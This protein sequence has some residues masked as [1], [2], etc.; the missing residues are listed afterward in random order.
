MRLPPASDRLLSRNR[1]EILAELLDARTSFV[2]E[3]LPE[4]GGPGRGLAEIAAGQFELLQRRLAQVP[5]HRLA[6]LLDMLGGS[7]LPAQGARTH[8][9]MIAPPGTR[10]SLVPRGA[11]IGAAV[12]GRDAPVVFETQDDVAISSAAIAE[13]HSVLPGSD[14]EQDHSADVLGHRAFAI[15]GDPR[16]V[17]REL[18]VGHDE[19]LAFDGRSVVE[20][21]FGISVPPPHPLPIEW[22]WWDG[23][24]WRPFARSVA[25]ADA[26]GDDDSV[27]GTAGLTRSGTVRLVAPVATAVPLEV[28]GHRTYWIRGRLTA[29][30]DLPDG[31]P[32]PTVSRLRLAVLNEHRRLRVFR[33]TSPGAPAT[34]TIAWAD[35]KDDPGLVLVQR[36]ESTG[37]D[38]LQLVPG[39]P[40]AADPVPSSLGPTHREGLAVGLAQ[41][42]DVRFGVDV[43]A[44]R[45][46]SDPRD[47]TTPRRV[48]LN[49]L[50][51]LTAP[52]RIDE[53][54]QLTLV[55]KRGLELD[56]G[57]ADRRAVDLT[58]TFAPLGPS[59]ERG[60]AFHFACA[61]ATARPGSRVTLVIERPSTASE[62]AD[63][64]A[65]LQ[66]DAAA[67]TIKER[68]E[69]VTL[70]STGVVAD[71]ELA[72]VHL[73]DA[74]AH[75]PDLLGPAIDAVGE[76]AT[77]WFAKLR[78]DL[79]VG[80]QAVRD[81]VDDIRDAAAVA[82]G[83]LATAN[84][85]VAAGALVSQGFDIDS[86]YTALNALTPLLP[87]F[88]VPND[89]LAQEP[90]VFLDQTRARLDV[91][92]A[93]IDRAKAK[94]ATA[95]DRL[96]RLSPTALAV[97]LAR[98]ETTK[99]TP[100]RVDWE[101]YDGTTWRALG[102]SGD[103]RVVSLMDSGALHFTVPD[104]ISD[105][106]LDGD[107]RRWLRARL[108]GGTFARM[109]LVSWV[110]PKNTT[111]FLS[112]VEP[113]PPVIDRIEVF[114]THRSESS[115]AAAVRVHDVHRWDDLTGAVA[116]P[117]TGSTPFVPM[118]ESAPCLYV[119]FD[120]ELP[121]G[122][123]GLWM[124]PATPSPWASPH[125]PVWE[126]WDG[127]GWVRLPVEDGTD[128]FRRPGVVRLLWP[129]TDAAAGVTVVG[130]LG[131]RITLA[132]RG[133][134]LRFAPGDRLL[135]TDAQ[136]QASV[137]VAEASGE[138]VVARTPVPRA[139][140]GARLVPAPPSRFGEP[141]T[142]VRA[143]FD[144][145]RPP[146]SLTLAS[147]APHA[148]EV[149]QSESIEG[150][151]LGSGDGTA[152][153]VMIAQRFPIAEDVLLEVR[154]LD[155]DRADLDREVLD[156]TLRREGIDPATVRPVIDS[157]TR[158]VTE[159]W[160]PWRRVDAL[161]GAAGSD[162]VFV[163]DSAQ[164]R[165]LFGDAVHGR[166]LPSGI[167]NVRLRRYSTTDGRSGNVPTGA[168]SQLLN[169]VPISE[170]VNPL[171]ATGGAEAEGLDAALRR[172][173]ALLRHRRLALT[174]SDVEA[175]ACEASPAVVRAR[176]V[177]ARDRWGR[178]RP[179]AVRVVI[180]PRDGSARPA[181]GAALRTVVHD[182]V[183]AASPA[184]V[185]S[186]VT[187]DGP[188]YR[189][190]G[191]SVS[192]IPLAS[193]SPGVVRERALARLAT[194]LHPLDGG[195]EGTGWEFGVG[196]HV[197]DVARVLEAIDGVDAATGL[198]LTV[199]DS[200]MGDTVALATDEIVCAGQLAV[201][202]SGG[203]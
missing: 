4:E 61:T 136:G 104:D 97:E 86:A 83:A 148:V 157:R 187:V 146:P 71:L 131:T 189:P 170:I 145:H 171:P 192:V 124:Q 81:E 128:G 24:T 92:R 60:T 85:P 201:R 37:T 107:V 40:L 147:L 158:R 67:T 39:D 12:P 139:F 100:P 181:P 176:A 42:R 74:K 122:W 94:L 168:I 125:R 156:R 174:E 69:I 153:Q 95:I 35:R 144:A 59:P 197:S 45:R 33:R 7:R 172:A 110:D 8:V 44:A 93:D 43:S 127:R 198:V 193:A 119:G 169:A 70:L 195:P 34:A 68:D 150:E 184:A 3:W 164:G 103:E 162:R 151:V 5:D 167:D 140:G 121:A 137:I 99:L 64:N 154:E 76:T 106:D 203:V 26:A 66:R 78:V 143:S 114:Y 179:G 180:V 75:L 57:V 155:G 19:L 46:A 191:V 152:G 109:T 36:D 79:I 116:W 188:A 25:S 55:V 47:K 126:G 6:V 29:P 142:W 118:G 105:V 52:Q 88:A 27:D 196:V 32:L 117:S 82:G 108:A 149:V 2:P 101:Y 120:A 138:L 13:V 20:L 10:S 161:G 89:L 28:D 129:G 16:A 72:I 98:P 91:V 65:D 31:A 186:T 175:I 14:A 1:D 159:V 23:T 178:A 177:G 160:V 112:V 96:S 165:F 163:V 51:D 21:E 132:G 87:P 63:A 200:P 77:A 49:A 199:D 183:V 115:N 9:V 22:E 80:I 17:D 185:G 48:V 56:K 141:R 90:R 15:F 102:V 30:F 123:I 182:A 202:L 58:K 190:V 18:Y 84:V 62:Q 134:G 113:R 73:D 11:R 133:A 194:F 50:D 135:L 53:G 111:N 173:P 41:L 166:P 38:D 54:T 130:A